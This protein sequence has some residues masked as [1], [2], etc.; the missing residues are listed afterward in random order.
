MWKQALLFACTGLLPPILFHSKIRFNSPFNRCS[1]VSFFCANGGAF[2]EIRIFKPMV[3]Y[4]PRLNQYLWNG[5]PRIAQNCPGYHFKK[6]RFQQCPA[7]SDYF[8]LMGLIKASTVSQNVPIL[9]SSKISI[10][11]EFLKN[12]YL[13]NRWSWTLYIFFK[14]PFRQIS[15]L[16]MPSWISWLKFV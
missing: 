14:A 10:S 5:W 8:N 15:L 4:A 3:R 9:R 1:N 16:E 13:G 11:E 7:P 2:E 12:H 6:F